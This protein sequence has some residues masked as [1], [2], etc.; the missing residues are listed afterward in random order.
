[1]PRFLASVLHHHISL[2]S[3]PHDALPIYPRFRTA[4]STSTTP[5]STRGCPACASW[6]PSGAWWPTSWAAG[7]SCSCI[8]AWGSTVRTSSWRSEEHTSELQSPDH[9]VCRLLLEQKNV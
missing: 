6:R 3:F 9:L 7:T 2:P 4:C 5:S 1:D 8:A